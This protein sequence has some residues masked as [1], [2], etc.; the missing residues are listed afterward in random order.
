[1]ITI[2]TFNQVSTR[3]NNNSFIGKV[4]GNNIMHLQLLLRLRRLGHGGVGI[5]D[6]L[7]AK[8]DVVLEILLVS[9][10]PKK[11]DYIRGIGLGIG[12]GLGIVLVPEGGPS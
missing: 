7:L 12:L 3:T 8:H 10:E 5:K 4:Q 9:E 11:E 1:M 6:G 2:D